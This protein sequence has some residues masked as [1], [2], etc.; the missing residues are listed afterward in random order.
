MADRSDRSGTPRAWDDAGR[1]QG[2]GRCCKQERDGPH[3]THV[4]PSNSRENTPPPHP[5]SKMM[6]V[7]WGDDERREARARRA[8]R[9]RAASDAAAPTDAFGISFFFVD[10]ATTDAATAAGGLLLRVGTR[11]IF[12]DEIVTALSLPLSE[13]VPAHL[14][15][16]L[17]SSTDPWRAH[18]ELYEARS[19]HLVRDAYAATLPDQ[20]VD[21]ATQPSEAHGAG[22]V[23]G[24]CGEAGR[25]LFADEPCAA[26]T[27]LL[28]E[29]AFAAALH[30]VAYETHCATCLRAL[31]PAERWR[32]CGANGCGRAYY[33]H[34]RYCSA[35]CRNEAW[36][37]WH[38]AECGTLLHDIAPPTV[39][40][41]LRAMLRARAHRTGRPSTVCSDCG[42]VAGRQWQRRRR[43]RRQI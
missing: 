23:V 25:G 9:S 42:R 22:L 10:T 2:T 26:G 19:A 39:I 30:R 13:P 18:L 12:A 41:C 16:R 21:D 4:G 40:V 8:P 31:E 6:T 1:E 38:A 29:R 7:V 15:E 27:L 20:S 34:E 33:C 14:E 17:F 36:V 5:S 35:A 11:W 32:C 3:A 28:R 43:R 37:G 24:D